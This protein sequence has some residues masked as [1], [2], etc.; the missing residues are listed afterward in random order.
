MR[1]L[2]FCSRCVID[3]INAAQL[4]RLADEHDVP[5]HEHGI[6]RPGQLPEVNDAEVLIDGSGLCLLCVPKV[7]LTPDAAVA[8]RL[9]D[10]RTARAEHE[11]GSPLTA[12]Q[13][14]AAE[15]IAGAG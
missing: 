3:H 11:A 5:L 12:E 1:D 4:Q 10:E 7:H 14:R 8:Q 6:E 2:G 9:A 13:R 15:L